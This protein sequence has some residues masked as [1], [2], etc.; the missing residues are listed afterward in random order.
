ML[1]IKPEE[2]LPEDRLPFFLARAGRINKNVRRRIAKRKLRKLYEE[3][4]HIYGTGAWFNKHKNRIIKDSINRA[5]VRRDCNRR[6]RRRFNNGRYEDVASG[7]AYRK[8][9][10]YWWSII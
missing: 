4:K 9:E 5:S 3:T 2:L 6:F 7:G 8:H 1:L 10:E